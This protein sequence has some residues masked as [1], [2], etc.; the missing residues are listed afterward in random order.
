MKYYNICNKL[1]ENKLIKEGKI[2]GE[3]DG[4][5]YRVDFTNLIRNLKDNLYKLII[6]PMKKKIN[7]FS[8]W[9]IK[10]SCLEYNKIKKYRKYPR[11]KIN[12]GSNFSRSYGERG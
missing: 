4:Y 8:S 2:T 12:K 3:D 5:V 1:V 11:N 7:F 6:N 10:E 9:I